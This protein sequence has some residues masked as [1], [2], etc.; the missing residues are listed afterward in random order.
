MATRFS[1]RSTHRPRRLGLSFRM[2]RVLKLL[3]HVRTSSDAESVHQ[4]RVA[5]RR[6]RSLAVLMEE[7]DPHSSWA[8][9]KKLSRKLFQTL[10]SLRDT[11]VP[12]IR[13][14]KLAAADA[15]LRDGLLRRLKDREGESRARARRAVDQFDQ[16][17]WKRLSRTLSR[18]ARRV[19]PS[20]LAAQCLA[21]ERYE[22]LRPLHARAVRTDKPQPWHALRVAFK[23]FRYAVD[24]LLPARAAGWADGLGRMQDLLG[25]I[26]DL[27]VI[28]GFIEH[29]GGDVAAESA[30]VLCR[31]LSAHRLVCIDQYRQ[32]TR[33]PAGLLREW[34]AGLPQ[35]ARIERAVAARLRATARAL[36]RHPRRSGHVSQLGL[37]IFD[38]LAATGETRF[39]DER[40]RAILQAASLLHGIGNQDRRSSRQKAA[41]DL[42][43]A[44]PAPPGWTREDWEMVAQVV[45]YHRGPEPKRTHRGL[46][47]LARGRQD[48]VC[49]LAGVLRLAR[50]LSRCGVKPE[51]RLLS[52]PTAVGVRLRL[53]GL[54]DSRASAA[55]LAA[56]KHLLDLFLRHPLLIESVKKRTRSADRPRVGGRSSHRI[57]S[58]R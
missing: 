16:K 3:K 43:R 48:L 37:Q 58:G 36:D 14:K 38:A 5:I 57:A 53:V 2:R 55:R 30:D 7:V 13:L 9:V 42:V 46:A 56:G 23:G 1:R 54:V 32:R 27:D 12:E 26:H 40:T 28:L 17:A 29:E 25:E 4:L 35:G 6:C 11:Q 22:E 50:A 10:G 15:P 21:L 8:Q 18:R 20:S 52:E 24:S 39:R 51:P 19:P 49:G 34:R 44:M 33:G 41:R 45:R 47:R 31:R